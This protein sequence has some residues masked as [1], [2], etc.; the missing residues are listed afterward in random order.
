MF[1]AEKR[2]S[3][4]EKSSP[5]SN[6]RRCLAL[7]LCLILCGSLDLF[8]A[9]DRSEAETVT[10]T[11]TIKIGYWGMEEKDYIEKGTYH[12]TELQ[13]E[14]NLYEIPYSYFRDR[15]NGTYKTIV[16]PGKGFTLEELFYYAC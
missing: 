9:V 16:A 6:L 15:D 3:Y 13:Q 12:W 7:L 4:R 5:A 11:L 10:D 2:K 8:F 1:D 14:L